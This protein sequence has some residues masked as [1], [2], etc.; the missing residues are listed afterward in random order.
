MSRAIQRAIAIMFF[1]IA[2]SLSVFAQK[3]IHGK[4]TDTDTKNPIMY[5]NVVLLNSQGQQ[6]TG[7]VTDA[8]GFYNIKAKQ[9]D[10]L[11]KFSYIGYTSDTIIINHNDFNKDL[12]IDVSLKSGVELGDVTVVGQVK[13]YE[14]DADK[15][16]MNVDESISAT[17][18]SAF[19]LLKS[20][21]GVYIDKDDNLTLNGQGGVLFQFDGRDI[22][23]PWDA[24]KAYLK[25]LAPSQVEKIEVINNPSAKYEAEGTAGIIN[26]RMLKNLNYGFNGSVNAMGGYLTQNGDFVYHG[27]ANLNYVDKKWTITLGYS[28]MDWANESKMAA[29]SKMWGASYLDTL[30]YQ[31]K[32]SPIYNNF[33]NL[34]FNFGADYQMDD[35]NAFGINI[36]YGLNRLKS[37]Q[38]NNVLEISRY[39]YSVFDSLQSS[40]I[41]IK[42][43]SNNLLLGAHYVHKFDSLSRIS[44]DADFVTNNSTENY[45]STTKTFLGNDS[46]IAGQQLGNNAANKYSS[47]SF[48]IDFEKSIFYNIKLE[49]GI[50]E[51]YTKVDN[52]FDALIGNLNS[53]MNN[54][55]DRTNRFVYKE[56]IGAGYLS[57]SKSWSK[58]SLRLG[59]RGEHTY[60]DAWQE[61]SDS[62][63]TNPY[64]DLFPNV[65]ASWQI[66]QSSRLAGTYSYR[67]TRPDYNS[68]NPFI[69]KT[70]DLSYSSG[71]PFLNP[72]Y[73]HKADLSYSW[74]YILFL[75]AS[76]GYTNDEIM[77]LPHLIG[78]PPKIVNQPEN[79]ASAHNLNFS[80]YGGLP[81]GKIGTLM[82]WASENYWNSTATI[83]GSTTKQERW[84]FMGYG[85][86]EFNLPWELKLSVSGFYMSGGVQGIYEYDSYFNVGCGLS[87]AFFKKQLNITLGIDDLLASDGMN[88]R[89]ATDNTSVEAKFITSQRRIGIRI[90]WNFGKMYDGAKLKKIESDDMDERSSGQQ[91]QT[92]G[93]G[94]P[95]GK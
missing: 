16:V 85:A 67:I 20:V 19:E 41:D 49:A 56:N 87:K 23:L 53:D 68:L 92:G 84:G 74:N 32:E 80:L 35:N 61:I 33:T 30:Q 31:M 58:A 79:I 82:L 76:Y 43:N 22:K 47:A 13:R 91:Q 28:G 10:Y 2:S 40:D 69:S 21:P 81:L 44:F 24:I 62:S 38:D 57:F 60:T 75:N 34:N 8:D 1:A 26:I 65:N 18:A 70:S 51:R 45:V 37:N 29:K 95:I 77:T 5:A 59:V 78:N 71:N 11:L 83:N 46:L 54:D 3:T 86:L 6:I 89:Y 93:Q 15:M 90:R 12:S 88:V 27:G 66:S 94:L 63:N 17:S 50:K 48:K 52:D 4:V 25:G 36:N 14:M 55:P 7:A 42:N 64:F 72:Q 39:P 9:G 73:T